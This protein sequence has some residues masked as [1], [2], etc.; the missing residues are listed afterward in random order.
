MK[1]DS[2]FRLIQSLDKGEQRFCRD[3]ISKEIGANTE[4]RI[5][6]FDSLKKNASLE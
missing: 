1:S 4:F 2:L 5:R 6:V 3:A